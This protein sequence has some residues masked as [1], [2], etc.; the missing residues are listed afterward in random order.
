MQEGVLFLILMLVGTFFLG[1][2]DFLFKK[3]L[4]KNINEQIL[5]SLSWLGAGLLL[6]PFL[7]LKGVPSL[8]GGF[9]FA[10]F[11]TS[12]LN[13]ISQNIF[14]RAFKMGD[15]SLIAP[16]RLIIPVLVIGTG[17]LFFGGGT[18]NTRSCWY[19]RDANWTFWSFVF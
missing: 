4:N 16:L 14:I 10:V 11:V 2:S 1:S 18:F 19:L 12:S 17:F 6:L 13:V 5:L 8:K 9:W 15:A 3:Y 7:L